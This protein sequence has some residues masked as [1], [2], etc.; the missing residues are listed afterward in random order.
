[1]GCLVSRAGVCGA[2]VFRALGQNSS[3]TPPPPRRLP[4]KGK[5]PGTPTRLQ[6]AVST[7]RGMQL[8]PPQAQKSPTF[9][10]P[11]APNGEATKVCMPLGVCHWAIC[12]FLQ[13][14]F[15]KR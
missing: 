14:S 8:P 10:A 11:R 15:L 7:A 12:L 3:I 6:Y 2:V 13:N 5:T 4:Q 9:R 1:M